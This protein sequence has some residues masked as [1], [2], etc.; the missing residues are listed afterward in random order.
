MP[1]P[2]F[3]RYVSPTGGVE[4]TLNG[5]VVFGP[6]DTGRATSQI[7]PFLRS[8]EN[9]VSLAPQSAAASAEFSIVDLGERNPETAPTLLEGSL[10]PGAPR[11][12]SLLT[13]D[14][15]LPTFGW[16]E[17]QVIENIAAEQET[18]LSTTRALAE[19]LQRGPDGRL[20]EMLAMK[21][22]E[23]ALAVGVEKTEI[24]EGMLQGI[25]ALRESP[26]FRIDIADPTDFLPSLSRDGRIVNLRRRNGGDAIRIIDGMTNP[27]FTVAMARIQDWWRIVR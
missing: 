11:L 9:V 4:V 8:G 12:E 7:A 24:D 19:A 26:E 22:T 10:S 21:H 6:E 17:A 20:L 27:G 15:P 5:F 18:L 1:G 25:A 14:S 23:L 3:F 16:H 13:I 2:F